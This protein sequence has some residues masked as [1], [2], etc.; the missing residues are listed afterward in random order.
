MNG[1]GMKVIGPSSWVYE[2]GWDGHA[3][4]GISKTISSYMSELEMSGKAHIGALTPLN[5]STALCSLL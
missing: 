1:G 3:L 4:L 2:G 5:L